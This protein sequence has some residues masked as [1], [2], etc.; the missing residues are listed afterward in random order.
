MTS[1]SHKI[2][3]TSDWHLGAP[4]GWPTSEFREGPWTN[5]FRYL[6]KQ[7]VEDIVGH[8][9]KNTVEVVL[10]AGD[11]A[12]VYS[13]TEKIPDIHD[14][15]RSKVIL[16]LKKHNIKLF[17]LLGSHDI[18]SIQSVEL[19]LSLKQEF[20][21]V[22][23]L[24][25]PERSKEQ[26]ILNKLFAPKKVQSL[27]N[28]KM[29][30]NTAFCKGF[31]ISCDLIPSKDKWIQLKHEGE[32]SPPNATNPPIYRAFGHKHA[33]TYG[34]NGSY[35]PGMPFARSSASDDGYTDAG[36]RYCLLYEVGG[37][38]TPIRLGVPEVAVFNKILNKNEWNIYYERD[39]RRAAW[40]K[41]PVY[42]EPVDS[43][44]DK[45]LHEKLHVSFVTFIIN[46]EEQAAFSN[47]VFQ[48]AVD[49]VKDEKKVITG[50]RKG[51]ITA[52]LTERKNSEVST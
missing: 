15:L 5:L 51:I 49:F 46:K 1:Q 43:I 38:V 21:G 50:S 4:V 12:D 14:F 22:V 42:K 32:E 24:L 47:I 52:M 16:P 17:F 45:V 2:L 29:L 31:T 37:R 11:V 34:R 28:K 41:E 19:F 36:P 35:Y 40:I 18:K 48:K 23:E 10:V 20:D 33:M 3:H 6:R 8:A 39:Y 44:L 25:L 26:Q 27:L 9:I 30:R 7:A 13:Y